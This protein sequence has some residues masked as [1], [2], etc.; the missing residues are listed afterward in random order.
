MLRGLIFMLEVTH[1]SPHM[2]AELDQALCMHVRIGA[3]R[4][5]DRAWGMG[6]A[7]VGDSTLFSLSH[8]A[9]GQAGSPQKNKVFG[10]AGS[11]TSD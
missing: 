6:C 8:E 2:R 1:I 10:V 11:M 9:A 7:R 3:W 5:T 4:C